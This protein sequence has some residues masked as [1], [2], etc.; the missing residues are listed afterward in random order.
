MS[1]A[2][3]ALL[4]LI[5]IPAP[6]HSPAAQSTVKGEKQRTAT[7]SGQVTLNGEPLAGVT[8]RLFPERMSASG[9]PR[10]PHQAVA[11]SM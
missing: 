6:H 3:F 11:G 5:L 4:L 2:N 1:R 7:V 10:W 8:V 9:D